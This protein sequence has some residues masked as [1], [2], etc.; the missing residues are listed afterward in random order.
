MA[1]QAIVVRFD[2]DERKRVRA[3]MKYVADKEGVNVSE[4]AV[5]R[6][7]AMRALTDAE[8]KR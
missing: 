3:Y 6:Q 7:L 8:G 1:K 5:I 4:S 2:R